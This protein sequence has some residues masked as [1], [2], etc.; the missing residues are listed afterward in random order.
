M[1][2]ILDI[3]KE[4]YI[5]S[6]NK[7]L[8]QE[9]LYEYIKGLRVNSVVLPGPAESMEPYLTMVSRKVSKPGCL[10]HGYELCPIR[11]KEQSEKLANH[12][13]LS[14]RVVIHSGSVIFANPE[15]HMDIDLCST[16]RMS[17][18]ILSSLFSIQRE[19]F[20]EE[21]SFMFTVCL[22]QCSLGE[23][24]SILE[25]TISNKIWYD[26]DPKHQRDSYKEITMFCLKNPSVR[27]K[28]FTYRDGAPMFSCLIRY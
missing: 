18:E 1:S 24:I 23:T 9:R 6:S 8:V 11:A 19:A 10:I 20:T 12:P 5:E 27:I 28:A 25:D 3:G 17:R 16:A 21:K 13:T 15:R 14:K 22:R 2:G 4:V 26:R 7:R